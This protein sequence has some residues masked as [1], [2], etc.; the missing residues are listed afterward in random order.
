MRLLQALGE[1]C[2]LSRQELIK[3]GHVDATA[4]RATA[5]KLTAGR[6]ATVEMIRACLHSLAQ[7]S[8]L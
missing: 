2:W 8:W 3:T 7:V 5:E 1:G 4:V 6:D